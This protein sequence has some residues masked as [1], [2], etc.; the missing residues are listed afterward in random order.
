MEARRTSHQ[1][2]CAGRRHERSTPS[3]MDSVIE[4]PCT[5]TIEEDDIHTLDISAIVCRS[6]PLWDKSK[7]HSNDEMMLKKF[8]GVWIE[9]ISRTKAVIQEN[10]E[11]DL[12]RGDRL[13]AVAG[14]TIDSPRSLHP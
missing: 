13:L 4:Y 8:E 14:E 9:S 7:H 12:H 11:M 3:P 5:R 2:T 6:H 1:S 10:G